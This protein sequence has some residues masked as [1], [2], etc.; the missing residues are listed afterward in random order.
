MGIIERKERGRIEMKRQ[1]LDAARTLFL[2][3]GFEKTSIRNIADKIEYSPATIYLY[4][5][6]KDDLLLDL[7]NEAFGKFMIYLQSMSFLEDPFERLVQMGRGYMNFGLENPE[8]Y[9]LMFLMT[10]PIET[11]EC[12][13]QVWQHGHT[14]LNALKAIIIECIDKGFFHSQDIEGLSMMIWATVHGLVTLHLTKR[15]LMFPEEER[16]Q[17]T[18]AG[19]ENLVETLKR[20]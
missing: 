7:H 10:S 8:L 20:I 9:H 4:F 1:I 2:E 3:Q 6:D 14:S 13:D 17:R 15:T 12:R 5:K 19:F 11:L 18:W 16:L